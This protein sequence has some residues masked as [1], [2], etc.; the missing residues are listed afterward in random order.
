MTEGVSHILKTW[1]FFFFWEIRN[2][3]Y[4]VPEQGEYHANEEIEKR[5]MKLKKLKDILEKK[6]FLKAHEERRPHF[7]SVGKS[8]GTTPRLMERFCV[9]KFWSIYS[10]NLKRGKIK[11]SE[12]FPARKEGQEANRKLE[13]RLEG[14]QK[15]LQYKRCSGISKQL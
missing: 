13:N 1:Q 10:Q 6:R 11:R 15:Y 3:F 4:R 7:G 9:K 14:V 8:S 12:S 2:Q 5:W